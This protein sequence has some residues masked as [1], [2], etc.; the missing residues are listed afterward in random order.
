MEKKITYFEK[1]NLQSFQK[2][3]RI[4]DVECL[5]RFVRHLQKKLNVFQ[6]LY[7]QLRNQRDVTVRTEENKGKS[8]FILSVQVPVRLIQKLV[9]LREMDKR[10]KKARKNGKKYRPKY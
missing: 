9:H 5:G 6:F 3:G 7:N 8:F 1:R 4:N 2:E 10:K